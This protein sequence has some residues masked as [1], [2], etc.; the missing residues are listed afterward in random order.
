[1]NDTEVGPKSPKLVDELLE[2]LEATDSLM[3][4]YVANEAFVE[5]LD[6]FTDE[7][8]ECLK[9]TLKTVLIQPDRQANQARYEALIEEGGDPRPQLV[10]SQLDFF[11]AALEIPG[12]FEY[13]DALC[14]IRRRWGLMG[15]DLMGE[16]WWHSIVSK[17]V[18][19][20]GF[21]ITEP[22]YTLDELSLI[23]WG[24]T[25]VNVSMFHVAARG[26]KEAAKALVPWIGPEFHRPRRNRDESIEWL[27]QRL[28]LRRTPADIALALEI[29]EASVAYH[30]RRD[31]RLLNLKLPRGF[32]RGAKKGE[33]GRVVRRP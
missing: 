4:H 21:G 18:V 28:A 5:D 20:R 13:S 29:S 30:V 12:I 15:R 6:L 22:P 8:Q 7:H 14:S 25:K 17:E 11:P 3:T 26:R 9:S 24:P 31:A 32:P 1:M 10:Q 23:L 16:V 19:E 27:Y 2:R 33:T